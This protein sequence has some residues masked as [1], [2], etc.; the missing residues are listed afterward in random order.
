MTHDPQTKSI[1][2]WLT[3]ILGLIDPKQ[4]CAVKLSIRY[5]FKGESKEVSHP[6]F[7]ECAVR[8]PLNSQHG[9]TF[10]L[11]YCRI[12]TAIANMRMDETGILK[13]IFDSAADYAII[14][15]DRFGNITTWNAGAEN[16]MGFTA[17]EMIGK[18]GSVIF[19]SEDRARRAPQQEFETARLTGR[20]A[21]YRWHICKDDSRFW[22]DGVMTLIRDATG[23]Q[24]GFLKILRDIT[25]KR[26]DEMEVFRLANFDALTGLANRS[27]FDIRFPHMLG[28]ALRADHLL[29]LHLI[30]LDYFKQVNDSFGHHTGDALLQQVAQRMRN[31]MRD[32]DFIA[33]LGGDEF[34][35]LQSNVHS[36]Q[37]GA[38]MANKLLGALSQPFQIDGHEVQCGASIGITVYPQ[39]AQQ[40]DQL[41]KKADLALYRVKSEGRG[42]F[43]YFTAHLDAE[44]HNRTRELTELRRAVEEHSFRLVYQP[45]VN[46]KSG[47]VF[48]LEALLRCSNPVLSVLP[49]DHVIALA[50]ETGL[51][52][53]ISAWI[54]AEACV[55]TKKWQDAG[56]SPM[57]ICVNICSRDVTNPGLLPQIDAILAQS[58]LRARS[59]TRSYRTPAVR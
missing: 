7:L 14:T 16:I 29:I 18:N 32:T 11:R 37:D 24:I 25:E 57:R 10:L 9:K 15:M 12:Q 56:L 48:A 34:V 4:S 51:M 39:D 27:S 26:R 30:D 3:I 19:T 20:A 21:D 23:A 52:P 42:G 59:R 44:A 22:G 28:A 55:Q 31:V 58:R 46:S 13:A 45:K 43:S 36:P 35:V 41:F 8:C 1:A 38:S 17:E 53:K 5:T 49:I 54:L 40:P 47:Q 33:R 50:T 6:Q 2:H